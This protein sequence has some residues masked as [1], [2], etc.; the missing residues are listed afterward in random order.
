MC[1]EAKCFTASYEVASLGSASPSMI[2]GA[3]SCADSST[4]TSPF[5]WDMDGAH[6]HALVSPVLLNG[7]KKSGL[8]S[9]LKKMFYHQSSKAEGRAATGEAVVPNSPMP[10]MRLDHAASSSSSSFANLALSADIETAYPTTTTATTTSNSGTGGGGGGGAGSQSAGK[11]VHS[12]QSPQLVVKRMYKGATSA[13]YRAT[14]LRSGTT[15][16]LKVYFLS[17][18]PY[19][20]VHMIRR[21]IELHVPLVHRNIIM[22]Y[23]AFQDE[24]PE[25]ERCPLKHAPQDNKNNPNLSYTPAIDIWSVGVLAYEMLVGFPPFV[26]NSQT[27]PEVATRKSLRFPASVSGAAKDF[28][29][30]TLNENPQDRPT[31]PQLMKHP[32]LFKAARA[33]HRLASR[34]SNSNLVAVQY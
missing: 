14:C 22:L 17:K 27:D 11:L 28:I 19:N 20:V 26:S 18:V 33:Q 25:V 34:L 9:G 32:W 7:K 30:T 6:T 23:A 16:A 8:L 12:A 29:M 1:A 24:A 15:V 5:A 4:A 21:E 13:V 3:G 2:G 10:P 31:A